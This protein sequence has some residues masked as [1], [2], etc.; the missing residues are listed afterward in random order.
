[1]PAFA[2][3]D[4]RA[5]PAPVLGLFSDGFSARRGPYPKALPFTHACDPTH[6]FAFS[7][8]ADW[9]GRWTVLPWVPPV[10]AVPGEDIVIVTPAADRSR[11]N[12]RPDR[13]SPIPRLRLS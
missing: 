12:D 1:M 5:R 10:E 13:L 9:Y 11:R 4:D 7:V 6:R 2:R 8:A 3:S